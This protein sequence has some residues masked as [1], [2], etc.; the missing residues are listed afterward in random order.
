MHQSKLASEYPPHIL[1]IMLSLILET[2]AIFRISNHMNLSRRPLSKPTGRAWLRK[3]PSIGRTSVSPRRHATIKYLSSSW[4]FNLLFIFLNWSFS[5]GGASLI[6]S[7]SSAFLL[8]PGSVISP[9]SHLALSQFDSLSTSLY[10]AL[11]VKSSLLFSLQLLY[12]PT[13]RSSLFGNSFSL[14]YFSCISLRTTFWH[15]VP[16]ESAHDFDDLLLLVCF[17][18]CW[19][20]SRTYVFFRV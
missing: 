9:E 8:P 2:F 11:Q 1:L 16:L 17:L 5:I 12:C 13:L 14:R 10:H 19:V 15:N 18:Y 3:K 20:T 7:P 4:V 6:I